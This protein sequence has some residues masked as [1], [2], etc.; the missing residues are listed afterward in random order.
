MNSNE[1]TLATVCSVRRF[2]G[3]LQSD[4]L[5]A[6]HYKCST[7]IFNIEFHGVGRT[8]NMMRKSGTLLETYSRA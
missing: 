5:L 7:L 6:E 1:L 3:Y 2:A 8:H 4:Y